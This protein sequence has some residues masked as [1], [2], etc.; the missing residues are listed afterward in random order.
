MR[1][2]YK[3][4]IY[5]RSAGKGADV[6]ISVGLFKD[7]SYHVKL[8]VEFQTCLHVS[9]SLDKSLP[10]RRL[11]VESRL[12]QNAVHRRN[13]AP[14]QE[15]EPLFF[16]NHQMCIRDSNYWMEKYRVQVKL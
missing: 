11:A 1:D 12:S 9:R 6:C 10:D 2:V 15:I 7:S 3:R 16:Q 14:A 4:Q 8:A 5:N 13:L